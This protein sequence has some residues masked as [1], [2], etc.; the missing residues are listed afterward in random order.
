MAEAGNLA[1]NEDLRMKFFPNS[2]TK[3]AFT[4][5]TT[6][7]PHSIHNWT[8][9][10]RLFHEQFYMGQS[11]I[12][13]KELASMK[14]KTAEAIDDYLNR[15]RLLKARCFTQVPEHELVE[16]AAGGLDY[17]IRKKLDTQHIRDMAQLADRV[18]R[19]NASGL[20][21]SEILNSIKKKKWRI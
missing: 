5:F 14:R 12:S 1:N 16:M 20:K 21:K 10:E 13:L 15:F 2:L 8:Q 7:P 19:S 17:S 4:W 6:L 3:N 11:R 18:D 9:L